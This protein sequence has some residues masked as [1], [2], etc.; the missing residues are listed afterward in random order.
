MQQALDAARKAVVAA[1]ARLERAQARE[2]RATLLSDQLALQP[3]VAQ[4]QRTGAGAEE[5][6]N[7]DGESAFPRS[8]RERP[9]FR[10][11][12]KSARR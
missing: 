7:I 8:L 9:D 4:A 10:V 3:A 2:S 11:L 5:A 12:Q 1:A 6:D